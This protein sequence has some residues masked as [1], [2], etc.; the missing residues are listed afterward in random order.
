MITASAPI[1]TADELT[2]ARQRIA[3]LEQRLEQQAVHDRP[4]AITP[5]MLQLVLNHLPQTIFWKDRN[6]VFL[7]CN[8]RFAR[9]AMLPSP[10]QVVGKTDY[11]MPWLPQAD[12]YRADDR[13]VIDTGTAK[14]HFEEPQS[15]PDG[16]T[17]WL[18]TSKIPLLDSASQ[19]VGILGMYEDITEY[20]RVEDERA[21]LQ[22]Q[23]IK[24]Q[25]AALTELSTPMI[26][27][28]DGLV[29]MPLIGTIDSKRAQQVIEALLSGV[30]AQRATTVIIDITGV[31]VIDTQVANALLR[32]A[33]A[34]K[35]LGAQVLL[36]GIRPEIAQTLVSLGVDLSGMI[37][38]STLQ[39][40]IADALAQRNSRR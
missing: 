14:L 5:S 10:A 26:P 4:H 32:A 17:I 7:G 36:T 20:K 25:Q 2:Q 33:Q 11:D 31:Q 15:R 6:L 39:A 21:Q 40:G 22:E 24:A 3:E 28:S 9:D 12:L 23:I 27:I 13:R 1:S 19:I 29:A 38:R 16:T 37:T 34:V 8:E 30:S 18:R 35:L